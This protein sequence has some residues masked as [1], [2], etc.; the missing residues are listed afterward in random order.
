M[1]LKRFLTLYKGLRRRKEESWRNRIYNPDEVSG[2]EIY[3]YLLSKLDSRSGSELLKEIRD[4]NNPYLPRLLWAALKRADDF[5][6]ENGYWHPPEDEKYFHA[7]L[8]RSIVPE[9]KDKVYVEILG[10]QVGRLELRRKFEKLLRRDVKMLTQK[11]PEEERE[12]VYEALE[13]IEIIVPMCD[14]VE[15]YVIEL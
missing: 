9:K 12:R 8:S 11:L 15:L 4:S 5:Y 2:E 13:K 7:V 14:Y 6:K 10:F 3:R 1:N